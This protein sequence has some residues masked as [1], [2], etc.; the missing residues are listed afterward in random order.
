MS[1]LLRKQLVRTIMVPGDLHAV[2]AC[3]CPVMEKSWS[4]GWDCVMAYS[5]T[6]VAEKD[7]VFTTSHDSLPTMVWVC[8]TYDVDH[9]VEYI[10]VTPEHFVTVINIKTSQGDG[11]VECVVTYTH[12]ALTAAGA[13]FINRH[14]TVDAFASDVDA[15]P[16]QIVA[17]LERR[18]AMHR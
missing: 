3:F 12:T 11:Q 9:E 10:R 17:F 1:N 13:V 5:R 6:G 2:F 18:Q 16:A 8:S 7:C 4:P 15:W 14:L